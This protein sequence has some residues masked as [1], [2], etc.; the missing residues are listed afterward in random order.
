LWGKRN[1]A[2]LEALDAEAVVGEDGQGVL[3]T[4]IFA[5][6]GADKMQ[7]NHAD[8]GGTGRTWAAR[9]PDAR[10]WWLLFVVESIVAAVV[11]LAERRRFIQ[12]TTDPAV[13]Q[14]G[15]IAST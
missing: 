14:P 2:P 11:L 10:M 12:K 1:S 9:G 7:T 5:W 15:A 13:V 4:G 3:E 8:F 6:V